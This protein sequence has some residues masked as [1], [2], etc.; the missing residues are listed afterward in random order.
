MQLQVERDEVEI[1]A[2][3]ASVEI[4][5]AGEFLTMRCQPDPANR[6]GNGD[7]WVFTL[8]TPGGNAITCNGQ[9]THDLTFT[10]RGALEYDNLMRA[11][12]AL[13]SMEQR[14]ES[15]RTDTELRRFVRDG[16]AGEVYPALVALAERLVWRGMAAGDVT[17]VLHGLLDDCVWRAR[18][19]GGVW[20]AWRDKC[21]ELA[22][23]A[24]R[25]RVLDRVAGCAECERVAVRARRS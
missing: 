13:V 4:R 9:E 1:T 18:T 22:A 23:T 15:R 3:V 7:T 16:V 12:A 6:G 25:E 5:P 10:I 8:S 11:C 19:P 14:P 24:A 20:Q 17:A 2:D 21:A